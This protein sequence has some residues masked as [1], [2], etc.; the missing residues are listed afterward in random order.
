MGRQVKRNWCLVLLTVWCGSVLQADGS[1]TP[2]VLFAGSDGGVCGHEAA[3]RLVQ[4][5]FALGADHASL[6]EHPLVWS[7]LTNYNVVVLSGLGLANADMSLGSTRETIDVLNR[8][9]EAGGGVLML[10]W[11]STEHNSPNASARAD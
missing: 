4:A 5:G 10:A 1:Q 11:I 8:Y 2:A 6:S 3:N 9:L 7:Q